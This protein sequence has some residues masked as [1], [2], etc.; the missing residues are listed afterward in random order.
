ME[1]ASLPHLPHHPLH[2][3]LFADVQNAS[4]L[5]EQ[6]LAGNPDYEYAFL[7]AAV[8]RSRGIVLSACF[9]AINDLIAGRLK[10]KNVHSEIVFA[11]NPNNN[12]AESF[13]RYGIQDES[14]NIVAIKVGGDRSTVERHL[15]ANVK[16]SPTSLT[17]DALASMHDQ[18]RMRK[19]YRLEAPK[20]GGEAAQR[21]KEAEAFIIAGIA[22]KGS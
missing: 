2:I 11:M 17:D 18:A 19:I 13:R 14:K 8:L 7:D 16:A 12:I 1:T 15:L 22:L 4:F 10:T 21:G 6:L 5:R 9:R 3:C 20:K